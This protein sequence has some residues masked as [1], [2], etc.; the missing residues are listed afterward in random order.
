MVGPK[1]FRPSDQREPIV[2]TGIGMITS[3]GADRESTWDSIRQG[4]SGIKHIKDVPGLPDGWILGAQADVEPNEPG[5]LKV[6]SLC[7]QAAREAILDSGV[8]MGEVD[9]DRFG[10]AISVHMGDDSYVPLSHGQPGL[11]PPGGVDWHN[12]WLPHSARV[13]IANEWGLMGPRTGH[14]AACAS[15]LIEVISAMRSIRSG[16]C[17]IAL[18]G[19]GEAIHPLLAAG[20]R[21]MRVLA[22]HEDPTKACRPF[23]ADRRGFVMGEGAGMFVV[24]RLS[25]AVARGATIY[26]ELCGG[27]MF[28]EAFHVTS[29][30]AESEVLAH[31]ISATLRQADI[32]PQDIAY[33]NAHGTGTKQNDLAESRGIRRAFA[34]AADETC[35][36]ATKSML[37]HLLMAAGSV[38]LAVTTLALR[39]GFVPPT[40]NLTDQ[41]PACDLDCTPL[42]GRLRRFD[43]ALKISV[44]FGGHLAAVALRRWN[45][46]ASGFEYPDLAA[47]KAA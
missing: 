13:T 46:A 30:D 44:A 47:P 7:R 15:G 27:K 37:G 22:D 18:A 40:L 26:A 31:T 43:H 38:E 19:S 5:E 20:F 29:L 34:E 14:S 21:A 2:I 11:H 39:D 8:D 42:I 17:D 12:Q 45:D 41:D 23:D 1:L 9:R 25:H 16:Q 28:A 4:K 36:S 6:I 3:V 33:I 10:C 24:E 35:V 32:R